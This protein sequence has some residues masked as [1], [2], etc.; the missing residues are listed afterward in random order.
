M[1]PEH[2]IAE[3]DKAAYVAAKRYQYDD[4][5]TLQDWHSEILEILFTTADEDISYYQMLKFARTT[6]HHRAPPG[7]P[8]RME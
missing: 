5:H 3:A 8:R 2:R 6:A 7:D 4:P 1:L